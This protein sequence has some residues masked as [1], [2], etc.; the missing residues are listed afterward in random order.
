MASGIAVRSIGRS[1]RTRRSTSPSSSI[2]LGGW[3]L[4][5]RAPGLTV[6]QQPGTRVICPVERLGEG[7]WPVAI[8]AGDGEYLRLGA[9]L[10]MDVERPAIRDDEALGSHRLDAKIIGARRDGALDPGAR[11]TLEHAEQRVLQIDGQREEPIEKGGDRR[12]I[13]AQA[14]VAI[15]Q[16]EAG[17]VLERLKR[18]ALDLACVEQ[19]IELAQRCPAV[20]GFEI[21]IGAE[22]T[23]AAGLTLALGDGAERVEAAR[24]GREEALLGLDVGGDRPE[25]R[26]VVPG[27]YGSTGLGLE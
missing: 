24:D 19:D 14:A 17:R 4:H 5:G 9:A 26:A 7:E 25:Q 16:S 10:R 6:H 3:N 11:Q 1:S 2:R 22:Q 12:E 18:A 15:G 8:A 20:D 21:V 13:L 27:W 23:L